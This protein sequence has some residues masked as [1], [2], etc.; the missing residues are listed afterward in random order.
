MFT[1]I[2]EKYF[3]IVSGRA[4]EVEV[5][6]GKGFENVSTGIILFKCLQL[7]NSEGNHIFSHL[8]IFPHFPLEFYSDPRFLELYQMKN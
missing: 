2:G 3:F 1:G 4:R 7:G 5:F 6:W 8:N